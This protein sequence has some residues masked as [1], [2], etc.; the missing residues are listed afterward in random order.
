MLSTIHC[1]FL[2]FILLPRGL[3]PKRPTQVED[4]AY[5]VG[6]IAHKR[7][8]KPALV[9][10]VAHPVINPLGS[11]VTWGLAN[12]TEQSPVVHGPFTCWT[13]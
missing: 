3:G 11:R 7:E 6:R 4:E 1:E 5:K 10:R 2:F 9:R 8:E 12:P 13:F